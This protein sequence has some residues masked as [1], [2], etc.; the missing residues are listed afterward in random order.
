KPLLRT[1]PGVADVNTWGGMPQQFT[2][3]IDPA[4]L[5]GY[6]LSL[7]DVET[8]LA[9]SNANFGAGY[10][11]SRGER[12]TVRGLGRVTDARDIADIVVATRG[13]TPVFVHDL[14]HVAIGSMPR[15]GAVSRDGRGE[16]LSV[17]VIMLKGANGREVV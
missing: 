16:A 7:H 17:R 12:L 3:S 10:L 8:A 15:D 4:K 1:V 9:S 6:N 14:G 5:A 11:E 2:V 13:G